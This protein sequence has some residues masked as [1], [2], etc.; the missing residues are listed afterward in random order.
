MRFLDNFQRQC[1]M[2]K[3]RIVEMPTNYRDPRLHM[4]EIS[5]SKHSLLPGVTIQIV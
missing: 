2:H 3:E 5:E 1:S 4:H